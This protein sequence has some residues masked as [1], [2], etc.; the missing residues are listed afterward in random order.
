[1]RF[2]DCHAH[3]ADERF[4]ADFPAMLLRMREAGVEGCLVIC[5]PGD[6]A[7]DH[8]RALAIV[9][10]HPGL[11]LAAACHPQNALHFTHETEAVIRRLAALPF[12]TCIGETGLDYYENQTS[13]EQQIAVLQRHLDLALELDMPVQLHVRNAHGDMLDILHARKRQNRLPRGLVHCFTRS[14]ALAQ[15][16]LRL[17]FY[18]SI[19]GP[20]TYHNAN[21]LL[22]TVRK[23]PLDRLLIETD[24]PWVPPEPHRGERN[25][26]AFLRATFDK[27][28]A[29]RGMA[30]EALAD[31]LWE[32][33]QRATK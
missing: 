6:P 17:G 4:Q 14:W 20:V 22:D 26:P 18:L 30:P 11:R 28:A 29:L 21:K 12:C 8:E 3:L 5:D 16:Y 31:A 10:A 7:P 15:E 27:I 25:E 9:R 33:A 1:M 2:F 13:K 32:N 24:A 23:M 19:G